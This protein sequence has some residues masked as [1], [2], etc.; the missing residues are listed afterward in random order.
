MQISLGCKFESYTQVFLLEH[1][2]RINQEV[3]DSVSFRGFFYDIFYDIVKI[4]L[5]GLEE[6]DADEKF[7]GK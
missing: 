3:T 6:A 2:F 7:A 4:C 1:S 5:I